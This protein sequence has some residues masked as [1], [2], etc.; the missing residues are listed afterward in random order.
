VSEEDIAEFRESVFWQPCFEIA[1]KADGDGTMARAFN[2]DGHR[3][4]LADHLMPLSVGGV[5]RGSCRG[6]PAI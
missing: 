3:A 1:P 4:N 2:L 6:V 5:M